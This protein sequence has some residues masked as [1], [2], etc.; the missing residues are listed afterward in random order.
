MEIGHRE[1]VRI[2][3]S[4]EKSIFDKIVEKLLARKKE[5]SYKKKNTERRKTK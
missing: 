1:K 4:E 5:E 3:R 2:S